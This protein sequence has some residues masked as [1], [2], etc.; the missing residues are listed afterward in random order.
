PL[1]LS[2]ILVELTPPG[3]NHV[4]YGLSGSDANDSIVHMVRAYWNLRGR[5]AKKTIISRENAYHGSTLVGSSLGG[6]KYMHEPAD[7]P[8]AG[9]SHIMQPYWY[10]LRGAG[11]PD[12]RARARQRRGLHRRAD[13]GCRRRHH[14]AAGLLGGDPADLRQVRA[15]ADRRRGDLRLRAY[16]P[17]VR[18]RAVRHQA[19]LHDLG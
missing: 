1:E 3:L 13:P 18:Q 7:L 15:A 17:L 11:D 6:M 5:R 10:G 9:F 19:G 2:Q 16:R 12:P 8:L 4:F 14:P